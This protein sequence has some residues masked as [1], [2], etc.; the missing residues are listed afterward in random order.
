[1]NLFALEVGS[2]SMSSVDKCASVRALL[3]LIKIYDHHSVKHFSR[4][5]D[6]YC[7]SGGCCISTSP[8][9]SA[10]IVEFRVTNWLCDMR[11]R[12]FDTIFENENFCAIHNSKLLISLFID[13]MI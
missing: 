7:I 6:A 4:P 3:T 12:D 2:T 13:W 5:S 11:A 8:L 10:A 9:S 1:M